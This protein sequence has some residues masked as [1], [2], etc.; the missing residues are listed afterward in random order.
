MVQFLRNFILEILTFVAYCNKIFLKIVH[1]IML[2]IKIYIFLGHLLIVHPVV[3]LFFHLKAYLI[4]QLKVIEPNVINQNQFFFRQ[5]FINTY[6]NIITSTWYQCLRMSSYFSAQLL[7]KHIF[8]ER[9]TLCGILSSR[10]QISKNNHFELR[11]QRYQII[12][13]L[14]NVIYWRFKIPLYQ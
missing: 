7:P 12:T 1:T 9:M 4:V 13:E 5:Y 10:F 2:I 14:Y 8:D 3:H 6:Q 11:T